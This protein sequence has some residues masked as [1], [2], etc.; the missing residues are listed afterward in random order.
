[1]ASGEV[2]APLHLNFKVNE[3]RLK[4]RSEIQLHTNASIFHIPIHFYDGKLKVIHT[5]YYDFIVYSCVTLHRRHYSRFI[6]K[7]S[8]SLKFS[9][10]DLEP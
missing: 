6:F 10:S 4:L 5:C 9:K 1:M 7:L 3:T 2:S 8:I